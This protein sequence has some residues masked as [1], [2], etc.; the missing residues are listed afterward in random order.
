MYTSNKWLYRGFFA[1]SKSAMLLKKGNN[2]CR[3]KE[4]HQ[5]P[6]SRTALCGLTR[7]IIIIF[8]K[9]T[10][11]FLKIRLCISFPFN[12]SNLS[13]QVLYV[14]QIKHNAYTLGM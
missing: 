4:T 12:L 1:E 10:C 6:E 7:K 2:E 3:N 13:M 11:R 8:G 9:Y 14:C 5:L